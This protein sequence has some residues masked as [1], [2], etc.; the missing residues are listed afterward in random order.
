MRIFRA[1]N[2]MVKCMYGKR[3]KIL[4]MTK[5]KTCLSFYKFLANQQVFRLKTVTTKEYDDKIEWGGGGGLM[6]TFGD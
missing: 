3:K 5:H 4:P 1:R 2:D 6:T